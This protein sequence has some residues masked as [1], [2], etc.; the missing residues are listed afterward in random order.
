[1]NFLKV[2]KLFLLLVLVA[3]LPNS[4]LIFAQ[5]QYKSDRER[6]GLFG[7]VK[8]FTQTAAS[9]DNPQSLNISMSEIVWEYDCQGNLLRQ[10]T[11]SGGLYA[12]YIYEILG[13]QKK[14]KYTSSSSIGRRAEK[15]SLRS[16]RD[17]EDYERFIIRYSSWVLYDETAKSNGLVLDEEAFIGLETIEELNPSVEKAWRNTYFFNDKFR[18]TEFRSVNGN[19]LFPT[20]KLFK[21]GKDEIYPDTMTE[22][23]DY[24]T[25]R[26]TE[27]KYILD[28]Q[29]NWIKRYSNET[30]FGTKPPRIGKYVDVRKIVYFAD[31][32][33]KNS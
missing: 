3:I 1:M 18:L 24:K 15:L 10:N 11:N 19:S 31:S 23:N 26:K 21:Y 12:T 4:S 8:K 30:D 6:E 14:L 32:D 16:I 5:F 13:S 2:K 9:D 29:Q 25:I 20:R 28:N 27:Y 33:C 17:K 7:K 22:E